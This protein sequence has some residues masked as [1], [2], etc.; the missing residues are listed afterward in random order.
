[1]CFSKAN[2]FYFRIWVW[3][4]LAH[5]VS[6]TKLK[7]FYFVGDMSCLLL[8]CACAV[9]LLPPLH[10]FRMKVKGGKVTHSPFWSLISLFNIAFWYLFH[11]V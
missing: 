2:Q 5:L 1:M 6:M 10:S 3:V 8:Q 4:Y 11:T 9:T 7:V